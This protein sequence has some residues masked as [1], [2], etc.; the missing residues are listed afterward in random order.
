[1]KQNDPAKRDKE[2]VSAEGVNRKTFP[3]CAAERL[4]NVV[5][6]CQTS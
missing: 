2:G 5:W 4:C 6:A 3:R 1:M